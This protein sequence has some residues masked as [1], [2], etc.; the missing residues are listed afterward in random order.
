MTDGRTKKKRRIVL[1]AKVPGRTRNRSHMYTSAQ[2]FSVQYI[3][4]DWK[5]GH[6]W[7]LSMDIES[8]KSTEDGEDGSGRQ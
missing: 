7:T 8:M 4:T 3:D 1:E 5:K 2:K 6:F